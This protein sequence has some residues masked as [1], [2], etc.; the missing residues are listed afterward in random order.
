M[1]D[2]IICNLKNFLS[3][4]P[5]PELMQGAGVAVLTLLV[6]FAIGIFIHHLGDGEKKRNFL[7][8]HVALDF[9]WLFK[10]SLVI[11]AAMVVSPFFM[12]VNNIT[13]RTIVFLLWFV[14]FIL[15][16]VILLRLYTWVKGDKDK[17]KL[18]YL[19]KFKKTPVDTA[20]SWRQFWAMDS[21]S[22]NRF[23]DKD[24]FVA[25]SNQI[26]SILKS[27]NENH[28]RNL[29]IL[30]EGFQSN[31][32]NR[33][34][35]FIVVFDEFFPKILE[36]HFCL[37]NEQYL[38][39]AK[40]Y[41][42]NSSQIKEEYISNSY[43]LTISIIKYVTSEAL[44]G[45]VGHPYSY[46]NHLDIHVD[47]YQSMSIQGNNHKYIYLESLPIYNDC[48]TLIPRSNSA[49][50]IWK[51]F[52]PT[53]WKITKE[54]LEKNTISKIW[55]NLFREWTQSRIWNGTEWDRDL[56]EISKEL[57]PEVEPHLWA[58]IFTF[59]IR[60]FGGNSKVK[61]MIENKVIFGY[62][63]RM[64]VGSGDDFEEEFR[65]SSKIQEQKTFELA[66]F[67]FRNY[68][69]VEN[70]QKW[71]KEAEDLDYSEVD[72]HY[73]SKIDLLEIF[74]ALQEEVLKNKKAT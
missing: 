27:K 50:D 64:M 45:T 5:L 37:W 53:S 61:F 8:L 57:F 14:T 39:F 2:I 7:D 58:K 73:V 19:S 25:F 33:N 46:F 36:W 56:E 22:D 47:K 63:G 74:K 59:V 66:I 24:F 17:F 35:V 31:I 65:K 20:N 28:W 60:P 11:T 1:K 4:D 12:G 72:E 6:S 34:K 18:D 16:F 41:V 26:D 13:V 62:A 55:L 15:M 3:Y 71:I 10:P 52:F 69:T 23:K 21:S 43:D 70:L 32:G 40:G 42:R 29:P 44:I 9:V 30:L 49:Y 68:F 67:I 38:R 48:L 51:S 54:N